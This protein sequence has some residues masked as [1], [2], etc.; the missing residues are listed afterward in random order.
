M[1]NPTIQQAEWD[2][3]NLLRSRIRIRMQIALHLSI[4]LKVFDYK[5][6]FV[7]NSDY[8]VGGLPAVSLTPRGLQSVIFV[9]TGAQMMLIQAWRVSSS[10]FEEE[11]VCPDTAYEYDKSPPHHSDHPC[12]N[13]PP[14]PIPLSSIFSSQSK[15]LS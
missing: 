15:K 11:L 10:P 3:W 7:K 6:V 4:R 13:A 8:R 12:R 5:R 2:T 9:L 1:E 14:L